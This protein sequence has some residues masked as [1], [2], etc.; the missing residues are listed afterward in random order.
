MQCVCVQ[1]SDV[2]KKHFTRLNVILAVAAA[3]TAAAD[4]AEFAIHQCYD[5]TIALGLLS[6]FSLSLS[7][8]STY[9]CSN[10]GFMAG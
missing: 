4:I 7:K 3:A 5:A 2:I 9:T 8:N 6:F 1:H 10:L